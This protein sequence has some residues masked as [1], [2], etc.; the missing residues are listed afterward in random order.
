MARYLRML[1][2]FGEF[3]GVGI[4]TGTERDARTGSG[5]EKRGA[6]FCGGKGHHREKPDSLNEYRR[7]A[8]PVGRHP[9]RYFLVYIAVVQSNAL[10]T[11]IFSLRSFLVLRQAGAC[12]KGSGIYTV[13]RHHK[14]LPGSFSPQCRRCTVQYVPGPCRFARHA[15][16]D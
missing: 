16:S 7:G 12:T 6:I 3:A 9:R 4:K 2:K 14:R 8:F 10:V 13:P 15:P 1:F 5:T 11:R